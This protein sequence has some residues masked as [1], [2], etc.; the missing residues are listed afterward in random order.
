MVNKI[1]GESEDIL[2]G[3]IKE[4]D[5]VAF[6][7]LV[8][9]Y[10]DV[11]LSLAVSIIKDETQ[12][13]DI[14][15]E[16]FIKVYEKIG[17]FKFRSNFSTWLYRIVVNT[18]YNELKKQKIKVDLE[19]IDVESYQPAGDHGMEAISSQDQKKYINLAFKKMRPDEALVLKL[20]YLCDLQIREIQEITG[21]KQSKIKVDLHRGRENFHF[22]LKQLL[23]GEI[24]QLL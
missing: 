6:R 16:V 9:K 12:A 22:R 5:R 4:G 24:N 17:S 10:K 7:L 13:E 1:R 2:I 15:Q 3:K 11:S 8:E 21:F 19:D 23:G 18:G 14:L 20:F